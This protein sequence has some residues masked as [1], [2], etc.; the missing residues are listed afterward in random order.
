MENL[1][2]GKLQNKVKSL[3]LSSGVYLMKNADGV[4]IYVGKA[5][6]L[7]NRVKSYFDNSEKNLK[8]RIMASQVFD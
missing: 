4:V 5:K 1:N 7:R 6:K 2:L 8:T 3:P